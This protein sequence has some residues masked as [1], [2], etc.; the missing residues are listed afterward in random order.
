[1]IAIDENI[2]K[3]GKKKEHISFWELIMGIDIGFLKSIF[4]I[5]KYANYR[6]NAIMEIAKYN[7]N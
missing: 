1:M 2:R 3:D 4:L 5:G 7:I 6:H